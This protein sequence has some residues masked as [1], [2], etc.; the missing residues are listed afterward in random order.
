MYKSANDICH[1]IVSQYTRDGGVWDPDGTAEPFLV[2]FFQ[3]I[4]KLIVFLLD[5]SSRTK[6]LV[7]RS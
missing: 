4:N 1:N 5:Y 7:Y 2:S 6:D 3:I